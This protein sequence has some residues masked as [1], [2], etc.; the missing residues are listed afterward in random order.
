MK[1]KS[2]I[3]KNWKDSTL[4]DGGKIKDVIKSLNTSSSQVVVIKDIKNKFIGIITDGDLRRSLIEGNTLEDSFSS[5]INKNPVTVTDHM[6][7]HDVLDLMIKHDIHQIPIVD[8]TQT[9]TGLHVIDE[10]ISKSKLDNTIV[11]MAGGKGM[12]LRPYT[13]NCPKPM[14]LVGDKPML[15][16]IIDKAKLEGFS[17]FIITTHY[18]THVIE[19]YFKDGSKFGVNI[20]YTHEDKPLGTAGALNLIPKKLIE[21]PFI[22]TNGDVMT[23]IKFFDILKFHNKNNAI[24]TMATRPYQLSHPYGVVEMKGIE[25][26][27]FQEKPIYHSHINAGV[28]VL[29]PDSIALLEAGEH[30]DMPTLLKKNKSNK[31]KVVAYPMHEPW[32]DIGRLE[33]LNIAREEDNKNK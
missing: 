28:Y 1:H 25:I 22:V 5:L 21:K 6:D 16:H 4:L 17:N 18:L 7:N 27:S 29:E 20:S 10:L 19:N 31:R 8:N 11:I 9:I 2:G 24:A 13:E 3:E 26:E 12:R 23:D 14:L 33:D 32:I 15:H 30:C